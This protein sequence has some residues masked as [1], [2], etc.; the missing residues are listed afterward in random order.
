MNGA[1]QGSALGLTLLNTFVIDRD[2]GVECTIRGFADDTKLCGAVNTLEGRDAF[3]RDL[4]GLED[5]GVLG[6]ATR[7]M[8]GLEDMSYEEWLRELGLFSLEKRRLEGNLITPYNYLKGGSSE[9]EAGLFCR[10]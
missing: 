5:I 6:C 9:V 1:P 8:K 10:A 7:P 4:D 2:S 3:Q